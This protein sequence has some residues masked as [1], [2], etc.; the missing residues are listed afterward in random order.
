MTAEN[1]SDFVDRCAEECNCNGLLFADSDGKTLVKRLAEKMDADGEMLILWYDD[2]QQIPDTEVNKATYYKVV[3]NVITDDTMTLAEFLNET[4][5][6]AHSYMIVGL[7]GDNT[8]YWANIACGDIAW[9]ANQGKYAFE[10]KAGF[11][12]ILTA[13]FP[14]PITDGRTGN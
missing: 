1:Y 14:I 5:Y 6:G 2:V 4:N 9:Y 11:V 8:H 7:G 13:D 10:S 12:E 3:N